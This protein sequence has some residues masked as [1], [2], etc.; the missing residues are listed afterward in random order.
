[1]SV[2]PY[3]PNAFTLLNLFSGCIAV[4][5]A[6]NSNFVA[7]AIFMFL[8]IFFDFFD[9]LLAR[10]LNVQSDL[11]I[12]LDSL[13]DMVTSGLVPGVVMFKL[14]AISIDAPQVASQND[15]S[16]NFSFSDLRLEPLALIGL[17]ITLASAYRLAKF[18][19]DE[20]QQSYFKGLPTPANALLIVSL[21]LII[22][23]QNNAFVTNLILN[24][25]FLIIVTLFSCYILNSKIK[26]LALKFKNYKFNENGYRYSL[27]VI[28]L[29]LLGL[30]NFIAI[31]LIILCYIALSI[32][33]QV[34]T[35]T[36]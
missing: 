32:L 22:E 25:W 6:V 21:P 2:K 8:G 17:F 28:A 33:K 13:A 34:I 26:L 3:I 1:M 24:K 19:I 14:I 9:G 31:P 18:N 11:G 5:F 36:I 35:K 10:K 4:L 23:F 7:A 20:D 16:T 15:W 30:F 27:L 12:Q 29:V